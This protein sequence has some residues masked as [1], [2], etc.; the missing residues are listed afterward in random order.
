M[1]TGSGPWPETKDPAAAIY[2]MACLTKDPRER[3]TA[4]QVLQHPFFDSVEEEEEEI[5]CREIRELTRKYLVDGSRDLGSG[6][7]AIFLK[8]QLKSN[9]SYSQTGRVR[10]LVGGDFPA[11]LG[12]D[13]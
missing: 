12:F 10:D 4:A 6:G 8:L 9:R 13:S 5:V 1:V 11:S 3:W 7:L 2:K